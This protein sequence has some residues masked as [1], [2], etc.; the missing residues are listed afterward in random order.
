[1]PH[2]QVIDK[3]IEIYQQ[4]SVSNLDTLS[5]IYSQDVIFTDPIHRIEGLPQLTEYF[6]GLYQS[7]IS[8]HF[9]IQEQHTSGDSVFLV[10]CMHLSH[11]RLKGGAPLNFDGI[12]QL[13]IREGKVVYHRD[14]FDVSA[15]LHDNLP[16]VGT[17]SKLIKKKAAA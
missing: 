8:G 10:W 15:M 2:S 3:F 7:L 11:S 9:D 13:T 1:M 14:F 17:V 16:I 4:L 12:S 6:T 5:Q